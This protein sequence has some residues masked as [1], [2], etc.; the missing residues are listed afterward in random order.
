MILRSLDL[1]RA[2]HALHHLN[3]FCCLDDALI[4]QHFADISNLHYIGSLSGVHELTSRNHDPEEVHQNEV[5]PKVKRFRSR[6]RDTHQVMVEEAGRIVQS[7]SVELS[8]R[9]DQLYRIPQ[10][11]SSDDQT[12]DSK[13][14]RSPAYG[15][16]GLHAQHKGIPS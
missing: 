15:G 4:H 14:S 3:C 12:G 9:H 10:R 13:A 6:V 1:L 5:E 16:H 7:I 2:I 8:N 11:M